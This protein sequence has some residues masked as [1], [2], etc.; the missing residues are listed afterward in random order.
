M[1][2]VVEDRVLARIARDA[3]A[4]NDGQDHTVLADVALGQAVVA[5]RVLGIQATPEV[6]RAV[7]EDIADIMA[8]PELLARAR[9]SAARGDARFPGRRLAA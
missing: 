6:T 7:T 5:L 8:D 4:W 1:T 3:I 9:A 2:I